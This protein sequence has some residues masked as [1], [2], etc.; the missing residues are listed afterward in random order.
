[1]INQK[2]Y[3]GYSYQTMAET[4][5]FDPLAEKPESFNWFINTLVFPKLQVFHNN[6][7]GCNVPITKCPGQVCL[8]QAL[9]FPGAIP[10]TGPMV[11]FNPSKSSSIPG[12]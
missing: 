8:L 6:L 7:Q 9:F 1:M 11:Q 3:E 2:L 5:S 10:Q 4:I 12:Q